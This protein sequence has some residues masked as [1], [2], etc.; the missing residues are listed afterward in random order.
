MRSLAL[1]PLLLAACTTTIADARAGRG[2]GAKRDFDAPYEKVWKA[3]PR[4][5]NDVGLS[6]AGI[7]DEDRCILAERGAGMFTWGEHVAVFATAVPGGPTQ[8]EVVSRRAVS[9]N[10]TAANFEGDV[11]DAIAKRLSN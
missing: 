3:I 4:A 6:V 5:V 2:T 8:V 7:D 11:L 9:V 1:V 10:F